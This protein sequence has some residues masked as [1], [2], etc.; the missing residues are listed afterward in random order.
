MS[1]VRKKTR[2]YRKQKTSLSYSYQS[3]CKN[4]RLNVDKKEPEKRGRH[5]TSENVKTLAK[6]ETAKL[7]VA[8]TITHCINPHLP[9]QTNGNLMLL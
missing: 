6:V 9:S 2:Q 3:H 7:V 8:G 4:K 1:Q 5:E